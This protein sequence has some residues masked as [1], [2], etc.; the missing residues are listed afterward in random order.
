M[1]PSPGTSTRFGSP[2]CGTAFN[3]GLVGRELFERMLKVP[4]EITYAHELRYRDPLFQPNTLTL[5]ISQSGETAD[6][7]A[8]ARLAQDKGSRMLALTNVVGSTL[9]RHA[10]DI[11]YTRAGPE[12]AVASTKAYIAMLVGQCLLAL[13]LAHQRGLLSGEE[14]EA[15]AAELQTLPGKATWILER[16][17]DV[18]AIAGEL[19]HID[20]VYFIGR[21]LDYGRGHGRLV[22]AQRDLLCPLRGHAGRGAEARDAGP[23]DRRHAGDRVCSLSSTST[24]RRSRVCRR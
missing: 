4:V 2:P 22:E 17:A 13:K 24:T 11:L 19:A 9:S 10:D 3:A 6:T 14:G 15:L 16:S 1:T 12:I 7:L 5:A 8:A 21:G 20:D 18:T 23:G